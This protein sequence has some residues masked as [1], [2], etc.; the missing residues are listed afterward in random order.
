MSIK[1]KVHYDCPHCEYKYTENKITPVVVMVICPICG[2]YLRG[3]R[4][5]RRTVKGS[6][7]WFEY[8]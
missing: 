7:I 8:R 1:F 3:H 5:I 4:R 6:E 2:R